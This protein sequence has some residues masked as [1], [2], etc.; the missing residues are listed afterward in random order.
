MKAYFELPDSS[1]LCHTNLQTVLTGGFDPNWFSLINGSKYVFYKQLVDF[2]TSRESTHVRS[3][4][5]CV[6]IETKLYSANRGPS[7][8]EY[9][10]SSFGDPSIMENNQKSQDCVRNEMNLL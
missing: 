8:S 2:I 9:K 1:L 7:V 6:V 3:V 5:I 4:L 10:R